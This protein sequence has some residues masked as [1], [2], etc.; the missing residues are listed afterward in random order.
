[1]FDKCKA[2]IQLF[3]EKLIEFIRINVKLNYAKQPQSNNR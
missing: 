2:M 1:M 3:S